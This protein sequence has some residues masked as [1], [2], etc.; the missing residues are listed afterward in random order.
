L[1]AALWLLVVSVIG[2]AP[3]D[4]TIASL[5]AT[6]RDA[7]AGAA[8]VLLATGD[9]SE[10]RDATRRTV[11]LVVTLAARPAEGLEG[12]SV[13]LATLE[14][15]D[16]SGN[17]LTRHLVFAETDAPSERGRTLAF[18]ALSMLPDVTAREVVPPPPTVPPEAARGLT[19][20]SAVSSLRHARTP[21]TETIPAPRLVAL[22]LR[23]LA[24]VG[25]ADEG[26]STSFGGGLGLLWTPWPRVGLRA[27]LD[28]RAGDLDEAQAST[29]WLAA[30]IGASL[31]ALR[32]R[33]AIDLDLEVRLGA[34]LGRQSL[35]RYSTD[36]PASTSQ[37]VLTFVGRGGL[38][39]AWYA[40]PGFAVFAELGADV[41]TMRMPVYVADELRAT[42]S[43]VRPTACLGVR[44]AL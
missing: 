18:V 31:V 8:D 26:A 28:A 36:E 35:S 12:T 9:A 6:L 29:L 19:T 43:P 23:G 37:G 22:E 14:L 1:V 40:R 30:T 33:G 16:P 5:E 10:P 2:G 20:P 25:L 27:E 11:H 24:T 34:G 41:L 17:R 42:L 7:L 21:A 3:G 39:L 32:A 15:T 38:A 4:P 44:V 13:E